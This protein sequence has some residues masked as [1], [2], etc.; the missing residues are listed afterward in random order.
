MSPSPLGGWENFYV[1]TG[2]CA[3]SLIGLTF[4]VIALLSE[5][6]K[7][8]LHG[9][10]AFVTPTIVHFAAVLLLSAYLSMPHQTLWSL[11]IGLALGGL[12]GLGYGG[13]T[14][15]HMARHMAEY[16]PVR[17]DWAWHVI[18]PMLA[19][20]GWLA[21]AVLVQTRPAAALLALGVIALSLLLVGIHNAWDIAVFVTMTRRK[22]AS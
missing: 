20:A 4:V 17:E 12:A 18:A 9:L 14:W 7:V 13:M 15:F 19:Y 10:K 1:I 21:C 5:T 16:T 3:G 22:D 6:Q 2:S 8:R 11:S